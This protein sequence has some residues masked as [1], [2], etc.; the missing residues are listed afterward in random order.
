MTYIILLV[1]IFYSS[2]IFTGWLTRNRR[3]SKDVLG[4]MFYDLFVTFKWG[5][6]RPRTLNSIQDTA[7]KLIAKALEYQMGMGGQRRWRHRWMTMDWGG[8]DEED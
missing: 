4:R 6:K 3:K 8:G 1:F 5:L 2:Y 7:Q